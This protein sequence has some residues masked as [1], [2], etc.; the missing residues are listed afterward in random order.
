MAARRKEGLKGAGG[1]APTHPELYLH[2]GEKIQQAREEEKKI[3]II[4]DAT[5]PKEKVDMGKHVPIF[6]QDR[7]WLGNCKS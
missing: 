6:L 7:R 4:S 5:K 1:T 3:K 2:P